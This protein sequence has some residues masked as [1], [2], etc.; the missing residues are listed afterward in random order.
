MSSI[1]IQEP[2]TNGKVVLHTTK[3]PIDIELWSRETPLAARNFIQLAMEG[4]Y[5]NTI[6]HRLVKG[7]IIQGG[8]PTGTGEGGESAS[9]EPVPL[10]PHQRLRFVRRGLVA[11]ADGL[12]QF[13][14]TL[15]RADE[16]QGKHTLFGKVVGDTLFNVLEM[17]NQDV[18]AQER[19]LYPPKILSVEIV[20]NPFDDIVPRIT[21]EE[22]RRQQ[23]LV[24][25]A[26]ASE[27]Q[28]KKR[29]KKNIALLSFADDAE[30]T[31]TA[32]RA[33]PSKIVSSHDLLQDDAT[34]SKQTVVVPEAKVKTS[35]VDEAKGKVL[36]AIRQQHATDD[37]RSTSNKA[38]SDDDGDDSKTFEQRMRDQVR[39]KVESSA[40]ASTA[41]KEVRHTARDPSPDRH[42]QH[43]K[44][45]SVPLWEQEKMRFQ[46]AASSK[47]AVG[48][49]DK[50]QEENLVLDRLA[51]FQAKVS[52]TFREARKRGG[53][54]EAEEQ[55]EQKSCFLHS[56]PGCLSCFESTG[57]A[58]NVTDD[59]WL[60]HTLKFD[61]DYTGK[62]LTDGTKKYDDGYVVID[63]RERMRKAVSKVQAEDR[64]DTRPRKKKRQH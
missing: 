36:T 26:T 44:T 58:D 32:A 22:R 46:S 9:G 30:D 61:K 23:E 19:P 5:D 60:T 57:E 42:E 10:E 38:D 13:F 17:A 51:S 50:K 27:E 43:A 8:D 48:K 15:D 20:R 53:N 11:L 59:G 29:P 3:G 31:E 37:K 52:S 4:Y 14:I 49:R 62:S 1:Y 47:I 7:F 33:K 63:P 25:R 12:S 28:T 6:F 40:S 41:V 55:R 45:K 21:A 35:A 56:V 34:L 18:D 54:E 16:L 24:Q 64:V 39:R 2:H